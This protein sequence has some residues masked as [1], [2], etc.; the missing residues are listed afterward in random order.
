MKNKQYIRPAQYKKGIAP[1]IIALIV[2]VVLGGGYMFVK[3]QENKKTEKDNKKAIVST[4]PILLDETTN[5]KSYGDRPTE[6]PADWTVEEKL[7][8]NADGS[9][10]TYR[11]LSLVP[12]VASAPLPQDVIFIGGHRI[13]V[14]GDVP[15]ATKC[16]GGGK[17]SSFTVTFTDSTNPYV[18]D[19][20]DKIVQRWEKQKEEKEAKKDATAGWK[21]YTNSKYGFEVKFPQNWKTQENLENRG[22]AMRIYNADIV[23]KPNSDDAG[24]SIVI[25]YHA[26][27]K[28]LT[29]QQWY[30]EN[31]IKTEKKVVGS[32][33]VDGMTALK[34]LQT[35]MNEVLVVYVAKGNSVFDISMIQTTDMSMFEK[36]LSTFKF[37]K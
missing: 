33:V 3:H 2:A 32:A 7:S 16:A 31:V 8:Y 24:Q 36:I 23:P 25:A 19:M 1:I 30:E 15:Q 26:N 35:G 10:V 27:P 11:A 28:G 5:W 34:T 9:D 21:T 29:G 22:V 14:C 12:P 4:I 6:Y 13:S 18:L 37:T 20:F 17:G